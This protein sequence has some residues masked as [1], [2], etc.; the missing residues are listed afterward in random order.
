M[1]N[2]SENEPR[3]KN[4]E[5]KTI[6]IGKVGKA[7]GIKGECKIIPL[8]DDL[9]RFG[10]L[11]YVIIDGTE[12]KVEGVKF[13][14]DRVIM[15]LEGFS[16]PEEIPAIRDKY[17]EVR[18]EDAVKKKKGEFFIDEL[19]DLMVYDTEGTE[20]G[21]VYDVLQTGSND[22][23]WIKEPNELL[24]PALKTIV[25]EINPHEDKIVIEP[26]RKWNY[27]D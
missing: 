15:K 2:Q 11:T 27:E 26:V 9:K 13:Q 18:M 17:V 7:H 14:A 4:M 16:V 6:V 25:R 22:V 10:K 8:T 12:Y 21:R 5:N 1:I 20:L 23:Y 3:G 19:K 24:I